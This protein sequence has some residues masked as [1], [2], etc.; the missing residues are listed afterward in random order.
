V[1]NCCCALQQYYQ[2]CYQHDRAQCKISGFEEIDLGF[3][4]GGDEE[5]EKLAEC[6]CDE[7]RHDEDSEAMAYNSKLVPDP[8]VIL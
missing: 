3:C 1:R 7:F 5:S 6:Y 4:F 2:S 8:Q